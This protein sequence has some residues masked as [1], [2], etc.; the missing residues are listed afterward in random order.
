[1][2]C[3]CGG[4]K[5]L[6]LRTVIFAKKVNIN[7][8]PVYNCYSCG[9][10]DVFPGVKKDVGQLVGQ[11]GNRP[12]PSIISFDQLNEWAGVL[13]EALIKSNSLQASIIARAAEERTNQLLDLLLIASSLGDD[14]WIAE[15]HNRLSQI[16]GHYIS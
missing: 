1:M 3:S 13:A 6:A 16:S 7:N 10:N 2:R 11:L 9:R 12:D 5:K 14:A 8:V 15:L 4:E